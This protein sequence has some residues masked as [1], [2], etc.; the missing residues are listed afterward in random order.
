MSTFQQPPPVEPT[1]PVQPTPPEQQRRSKVPLIV[2]AV[3]VAVLVL[4]LAAVLTVRTITAA[5]AVPSGEL[6]EEKPVPENPVVEALTA[7]GLTC[8]DE[9]SEPWMI[10]GCYQVEAGRIV[11]VRM[12]VTDE[13]QVEKFQVQAMDRNAAPKDRTAEFLELTTLMFDASEVGAADRKLITEALDQDKDYI[14]EAIDWGELYL[15]KQ[16]SST[17]TM[18]L[19]KPDVGEPPDKSVVAA[20]PFLETLKE[21]GYDCKADESS[22]SCTG[23]LAGAEIRGALHQG[24]ILSMNV[25]WEG[26]VIK[27][28]HETMIDTYAAL[29]ADGSPDAEAIRQGL[30]KMGKEMPERLYVKGFRIMRWE[31]R[32]SIE[33]VS[34]V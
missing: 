9:M 3:V 7:H 8:M 32:Y 24:A 29:A 19:T 20:A 26:T 21:R 4:G 30:A 22:Y 12:K 11:M 34:F 2:L 31:T 16:T 13:A 5:G 27:A 23:E 17:T 6:P 18:I 1:P 15:P 33:S 28:D 10:K 25:G 14:F